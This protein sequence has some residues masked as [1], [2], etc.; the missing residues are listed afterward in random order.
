MNHH[1]NIILLSGIQRVIP[2]LLLF[3]L[4]A[5]STQA[6]DQNTET[7]EIE[8]PQLQD[9]SP[10]SQ[11]LSE[12]FQQRLSLFY[13][14]DGEDELGI[15]FKFTPLEFSAGTVTPPEGIM[16]FTQRERYAEFARTGVSP[17][18]LVFDAASVLNALF[19]GTNTVRR[20]INYQ[21]PQFR[22]VNQP[23]EIPDWP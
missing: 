18:D 15:S 7:S 19:G 6:Q 4:T 14:A 16:S 8:S 9:P 22:N 1:T 12:E 11:P 23:P 5:T 20:N 2:V 17:T 21:A 3:I 13:A 10:V